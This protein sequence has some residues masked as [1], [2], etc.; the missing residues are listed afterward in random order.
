MTDEEMKQLALDSGF[1]HAAFMDVA[2]LEFDAALRQ[3]CVENTCGNY[4]RNY[5]C[6]PECGTPGEMEEKVRKYKR[7][8]VLESVQP[9]GSVMDPEETKTAKKA[10][11]MISRE[12]VNMMKKECSESSA[13]MAGPCTFCKT[14]AQIEGKPCRFPE[15]VYSCLSA[16]CIDAGKM[17]E[18]CGL[19][20]WC[21]MDKVAFFSIYLFN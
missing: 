4:D 1:T 3:Y 20:Y 5:A 14:C 6:P 8:L 21:G 13:V 17:A 19:P 2:D 11:N 7:A 18:H 10:H 9:V 16:Y 15:E 12:F